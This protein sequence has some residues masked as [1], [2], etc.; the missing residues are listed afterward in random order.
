MIDLGYQVSRKG[1]A[2]NSWGQWGNKLLAV[3]A[4]I[5]SSKVGSL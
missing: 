4:A 3:G 2:D 1:L 5:S